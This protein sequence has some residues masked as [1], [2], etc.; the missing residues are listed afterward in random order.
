M[1]YGRRNEL[2]ELAH[3]KIQ[4][5]PELYLDHVYGEHEAGGTSWLFLAPK[6]YSFASLGFIDLDSDAPPERT[7]AIQ[8]GV[9]KYWFPPLA[10]YAVLGAMMWITQPEPAKEGKSAGQGHG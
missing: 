7:E 10:W 4:K 6:D 2:V 1:T 5:E 9:F 3:E 8:H